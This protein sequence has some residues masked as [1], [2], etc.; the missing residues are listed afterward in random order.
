V[1][2]QPSHNKAQRAEEKSVADDKKHYR[3]AVS[4]LRLIAS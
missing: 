1:S 4:T 3:S 2:Q